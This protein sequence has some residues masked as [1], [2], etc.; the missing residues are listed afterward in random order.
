[1]LKIILNIIAPLLANISFK[2]DHER[3]TVRIVTDEQDMELSYEQV[4]CE[5]ENI[6]KGQ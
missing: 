3:Q 1:M 2:V 6:I 4:I 5:L